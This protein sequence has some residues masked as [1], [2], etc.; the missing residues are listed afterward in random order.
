VL[1]KVFGLQLHA[2]SHITVSG[3]SKYVRRI[4]QQG[5]LRQNPVTTSISLALSMPSLLDWIVCVSTFSRTD[6]LH[7]VLFA[8]ASSMAP[9]CHHVT[10]GSMIPSLLRSFLIQLS[11]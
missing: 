3:Y 11:P 2:T 8:V 5:K 9:V 7:S 1:L 6:Q 10:V 4:P